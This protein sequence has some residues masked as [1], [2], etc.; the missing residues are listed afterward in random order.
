MT[1]TVVRWNGHASEACRFLAVRQVSNAPAARIHDILDAGATGTDDPVAII[2]DAYT[3]AGL[4]EL[5]VL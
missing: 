1:G 5:E 4:F 3:L 2:A